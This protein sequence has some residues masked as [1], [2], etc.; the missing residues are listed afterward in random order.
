MIGFYDYTVITTFIGLMSSIFGIILSVNGK[1]DFAIVLLAFSG[2]CD[3]LDGKIARRKKNRTEDEKRY[4][5]ELDSLCDIVCFGV[6]P[7]VFCY[8]LCMRGKLGVMILLLYCI[9]GVIR[10]AYFNVM[11]F[12]RQSE[13][14]ENRKEYKGLPITS[15]SVVLPFV[16]MI[17][18]CL[19]ER[20]EIILYIAMLFVG[21]L[22]VVDFKFKKPSNLTLALL[23]LAVCAALIIICERFIFR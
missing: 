21:V 12:R 6:F 10:L 13:T 14:S 9:C 3:M 16:Y 23:V 19:P 2:L 22:F 8:K 1:F 7:V 5:I 18:K 15:I 4:G 11:E 17:K 20:F